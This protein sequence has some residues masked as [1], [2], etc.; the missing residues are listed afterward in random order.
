[1][2]E[3]ARY[4]NLRQFLRDRKS[5]AR[6]KSIQERKA[7]QADQEEMIESDCLQLQNSDCDMSECYDDEYQAVSLKMML[8]FALQVSRGME[9]LSSRRCVHRDLAARN[10]L[11][12][13]NLVLKIADFGMAR[14]LQ[15]SEYYRKESDGRLP[16]KWMSPESLF[17]RISTTMSDVWSF[18]VLFW[19]IVTFGD[20]PYKTEMSPKVF[21]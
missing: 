3:Y 8:S 7:R 14:D 1:M 15:D 17:S 10:I 16:I 9:F 2:V 21:M 5:G 19:E 18:G 6:L 11:V 12:S 4:G 20:N 13:D